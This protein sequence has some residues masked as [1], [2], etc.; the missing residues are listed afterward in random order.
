M[1]LFQCKWGWEFFTCLKGICIL[2]L[3]N[4]LFISLAHFPMRLLILLICS[5]FKK[6]IFISGCTGSSLLLHRLFLVV[7]GGD[8]LH[9]SV[10]ASQCSGFSR[11]AQALGAQVLVAV[12]YRLSCSA[13]CDIFPDQGLNPCFLHWQAE[14]YPLHHQGS[15]CSSFF[16]SQRNWFLIFD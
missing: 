8:T 9:C 4:C 10:Q 1:R 6:K 13:A 16:I 11:G 12:A 5:R 3:V 15:P 14:S 7:A 2:F